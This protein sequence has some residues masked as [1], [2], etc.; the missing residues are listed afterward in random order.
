M[1]IYFQRPPTT[2]RWAPFG[3]GAEQP[4]LTSL[5]TDTAPPSLAAPRAPRCLQGWCLLPFLRGKW[6][7]QKS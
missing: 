6:D 7:M 4:A 3:V 2:E 1:K 5:H